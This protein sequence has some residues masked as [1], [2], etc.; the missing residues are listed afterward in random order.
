MPAGTLAVQSNTAPLTAE[1]NVTAAELVPEHIVC[2][3]GAIVTS[4]V[5]LIVITTV[6]G[7][8]GHPTALVYVGVIV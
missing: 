3:P 4:G 6:I 2:G 1:L 7:A 8:P 5:G